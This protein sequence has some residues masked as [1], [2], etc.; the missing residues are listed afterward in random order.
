MNREFS[1]SRRTFLAASGF[2][3]AGAALPGGLSAAAD[4]AAVKNKPIR[5]GQIGTGNQHASK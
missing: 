2:A 1:F 5:I 4:G 3:A